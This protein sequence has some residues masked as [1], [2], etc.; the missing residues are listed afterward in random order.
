VD[1]ICNSAGFGYNGYN[2]LG[3]AQWDLVTGVDIW[4][5]EVQQD[6]HYMVLLYTVK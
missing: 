3:Y 6:Q 1:G 4:A 5:F 2:Q